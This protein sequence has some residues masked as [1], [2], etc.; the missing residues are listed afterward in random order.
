ML[1]TM[2]RRVTKR[3]WSHNFW[4]CFFDFFCMIGNGITISNQGSCQTVFCFAFF[5]KILTMFYRSWF[6][7]T[8]Q[9]IHLYDIV[10]VSWNPSFGLLK[11][12]EW[13]RVTQKTACFV[14]PGSKRFEALPGDVLGEAQSGHKSVPSLIAEDSDSKPATGHKQGQTNGW[15][16]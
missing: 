1:E 15:S 2:V 10:T 4:S 11:F 8:F 3:L 7:T 5:W 16:C 6:E 14:W 13:W 12:V 9:V